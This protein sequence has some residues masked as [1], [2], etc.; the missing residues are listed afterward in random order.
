M[1]GYKR[2]D[3]FEEDL[4]VVAY[5]WLLARRTSQSAPALRMTSFRV[6]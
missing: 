6:Q 1:P 2:V 3:V 4:A 5:S